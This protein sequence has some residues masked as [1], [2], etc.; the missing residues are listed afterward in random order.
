MKRNKESTRA[1]R[2]RKTENPKHSKAGNSRY[3][4]KKAAGSR[5]YADQ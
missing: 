2:Q 1:M 4:Q 5:M 3:G